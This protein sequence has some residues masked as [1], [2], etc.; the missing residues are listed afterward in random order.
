MFEKKLS[1]TKDSCFLKTTFGAT[2]DYSKPL[3]LDAL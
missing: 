1:F 2:E 3:I